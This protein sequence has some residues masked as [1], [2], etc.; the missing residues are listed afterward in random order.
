MCHKHGISPAT[1]YKWESKY[2]GLSMFEFKRI[3]E[4]ESGTANLKRMFA[5]VSMEDDTLK[6]FLSN[7]P[8]IAR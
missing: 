6:D 8:R 5:D 3:K 4:M 1:Y 2:G 7:S